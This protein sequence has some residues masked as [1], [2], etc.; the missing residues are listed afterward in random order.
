MFPRPFMLKRHELV[1]VH[2]AAIQQP[3]VFS[4]DALGQI[5]SRWKFSSG[6]TAGH[7]LVGL[8]V[9][10]WK[11]VRTRLGEKET[12]PQVGILARPI[13]ERRTCSLNGR[14]IQWH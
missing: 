14:R 2:R 6:I 9:Y 13:S 11:L 4:V 5:V 8:L 7:I 3:L 10:V 1:R 12:M